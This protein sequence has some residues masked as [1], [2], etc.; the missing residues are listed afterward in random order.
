MDCSAEILVRVMS[1][2]AAQIL[3]EPGETVV[4]VQQ[5]GYGAQ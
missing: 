5:R 4:I 1:E 2:G 3:T